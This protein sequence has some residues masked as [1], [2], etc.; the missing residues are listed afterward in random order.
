MDDISSTLPPKIL[1][2]GGYG[3]TGRALAPLL[4]KYTTASVVISGRNLDKAQAFA[5]ELEHEHEHDHEPRVSTAKVDASDSQSLLQAFSTDGVTLV[6]VVSTTSQHLEKVA[7]AALD[8]KIDYM[9]IHLSSPHKTS[10]LESI[11][12]KI[13]QAGLCFIT[14]GGF[15]PGLPAAMIRY[16][17]SLSMFSQLETALVG[18]VIQLDWNSCQDNMS[19]NA[20]EEFASEL[21]NMQSIVYRDSKW[22]DLGLWGAM[23]LEKPLYMDF[24]EPFGSRPLLPMHLEEMRCIPTLFPSVKA[25]AFHVGGFNWVVDYLLS[26]P[27]FVSIKLFPASKRVMGQLLYWG[28]RTFSKPPF[29]TILKVEATGIDAKGDHIEKTLL[30]AH[31]DGYAV[32]AIPVAATVIQYLS[33][34]TTGSIRKPG[35]WRQAVVVEPRRFF[36]DLEMMG[37]RIEPRVA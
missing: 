16:L 10:F 29:G 19:A 32:T 2:L 15:H 34:S 7:L 25:T 21:G 36:R 37:V 33:P 6:I 1:L 30:L 24:G 26:P 11:E 3:N 28:L 17:A 23:V 8:A 12:D 9:D 5:K 14:D 35:L 22:H 13:T 18:S 31:E 4:L 27:V 20:A